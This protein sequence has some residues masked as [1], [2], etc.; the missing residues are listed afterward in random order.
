MASEQVRRSP[1]RDRAT[2]EL[3]ARESSANGRII[4]RRRPLI[5]ERAVRGSAS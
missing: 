5:N 2:V 4:A 3:F 1:A